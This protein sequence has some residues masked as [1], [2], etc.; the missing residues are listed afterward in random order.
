M[1]SMKRRATERT[2]RESSTI[3][4]LL[5][6]GSGTDD[7]GR[8][9][10]VSSRLLCLIERCV[11]PLDPLRKRF[12]WFV[13]GDANRY[14]HCA[15]GLIEMAR[16]IKS[17]RQRCPDILAD[18][19]GGVDRCGGQDDGELLA[20]VARDAIL[21]LDALC[22]RG[23][24][25]L[26]DG[27]AGGVAPGVVDLFE[28]IDVDQ[29]QRQI[30]TAVHGIAAHRLQNHVEISSVR[31]TGQAVRRG[32]APKVLQGSFQRIDLVGRLLEIRSEERR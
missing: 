7:S 5:I 15:D 3:R 21:A 18:M 28:M 17:A 26:N 32:L 30:V 6:S 23:G 16:D 20:A 10:T 24:N 9:D 19:R 25:E 31:D 12:T 8:D 27:V 13:A 1:A 4:H 22:Q 11:S 2:T 29:E 14:R